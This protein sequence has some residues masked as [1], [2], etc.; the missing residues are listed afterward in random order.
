ME[1]AWLAIKSVSDVYSIWQ[2]VSAIGITAVLSSVAIATVESLRT[3]LNWF[4]Q[5]WFVV[6]IFLLLVVF[7]K[8]VLPPLLRR[9]STGKVGAQPTS[10]P[11]GIGSTEAPVKFAPLIQHDKANLQNLIVLVDKRV[12]WTALQE[13]RDASIEFSFTIF[14]GSVLTLTPRGTIGQVYCNGVRLDTLLQLVATS[15]HSS[16][17]E[18]GV[19]RELRLRQ[20]LD[21]TNIVTVWGGHGAREFSFGSVDISFESKAPDGTSGPTVSIPLPGDWVVE[22]PLENLPN[23]LKSFMRRGEGFLKRTQEVPDGDRGGLDD[24]YAT[25]IEWIGSIALVL[26]GLGFHEKSTQ[27]LSDRPITKSDDW[28]HMRDQ[29]MQILEDR[30]QRTQSHIAELTKRA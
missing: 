20:I 16:P 18:H 21:S 2:L 19:R 25:T 24:L 3:H 1:K 11:T 8:C 5:A 28:E 23:L 4:G 15:G 14:N 6:G 13:Q 29:L 22:H 30:L 7:S 26:D 12:D 9:L 27:M 10:V 17:L